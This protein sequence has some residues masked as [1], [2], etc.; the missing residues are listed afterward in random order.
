MKKIWRVIFLIMLFLINIYLLIDLA[1]SF[2]TSRFI[3]SLV[4][5][6]PTLLF[7]V[8]YVYENIDI[9]FE[10]YNIALVRFL[11]PT[12]DWSLEYRYSTKEIPE[13]FFRNIQ[14][15]LIDSF[16]DVKTKNITHINMQIE[17]DN[18]SN[19]EFS[20]KD[21]KSVLDQDSRYEVF[22]KTNAKISYR[23]SLNNIFNN[24]EKVINIVRDMIG[25]TKN[26]V[27]ILKVKF[28]EHNP[29]VKVIPKVINNKNN[30]S[31]K[32][33]YEINKTKFSSYNNTLEIVTPE[34]TNIQKL[35]KKYI[36]L[37]NDKLFN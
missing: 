6:V 3:N 37:S 36:A 14:N 20:I 8:T 34:L 21:T 17:L 1:V 15:S 29:F 13:D 23:D 19:I 12:V 31:Y 2:N 27:Y 33:N 24:Y 30:F 4:S 18:F 7:T 22:I 5:Y 9:V 25:F 10:K 26:P 11:N 35:S 28:E 16:S 32:I